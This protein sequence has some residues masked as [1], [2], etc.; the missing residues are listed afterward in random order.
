MRT[1]GEATEAF[2]RVPVHMREGLRLYVDEHIEP[3]SFLRAVLEN[4]LSLSFQRADSINRYA[5]FDIVSYLYNWCPMDCW[6]SPERVEKWLKA[7]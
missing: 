5:L 7:R 3:G 1:A 6:G 4:N 2:E